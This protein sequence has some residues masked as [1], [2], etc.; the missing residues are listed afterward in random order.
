[1]SEVEKLMVGSIAPATTT[2]QVEPHTGSGSQMGNHPSREVPQVGDRVLVDLPKT[3]WDHRQ[4]V[5]REIRHE[6]GQSSQG[7][8]YLDCMLVRFP[9]ARLRRA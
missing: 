8:V 1:M 6:A 7:F 3:R 2:G 4:G 9:L 5:L